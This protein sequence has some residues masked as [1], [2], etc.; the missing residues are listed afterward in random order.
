MQST[1]ASLSEHHAGVGTAPRKIVQLNWVSEEL[2]YSSN[3]LLK[4]EAGL[5]VL[6]EMAVSNPETMESP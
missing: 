3:V 2:K 4:N 1:Q 6:G 5:K